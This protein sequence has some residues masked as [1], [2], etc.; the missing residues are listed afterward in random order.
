M[1]VWE[2]RKG[3]VLEAE[4]KGAVSGKVMLRDRNGKDYKL[5]ISGLS[6]KDQKY[7]QTMMPPKIEIKFSKKQD[8]KNNSYTVEMLGQVTLTKTSRMPYSSQLKA[9]LFMIGEDSYDDEYI[10]MDKTEYEFNFK[11]EKTHSFSGKKFKMQH[12]RYSGSDDGV[13]YKG[14]LVVVYDKLGNALV[15]KSSSEVL[16]SNIDYLAPLKEGARFPDDMKGKP[17]RNSSS[18][19]HYY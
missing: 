6:E 14:Y 19:R 8:R 13:E 3:N 4:F 10:M 11:T 7:I 16:A 18:S 5:S 1:R 2:D 15:V 17:T 9:T 12:Y